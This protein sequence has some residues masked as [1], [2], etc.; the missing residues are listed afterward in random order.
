MAF[1]ISDLTQGT[2]CQ[3]R[4]RSFCLLSP[5]LSFGSWSC[6]NVT[7]DR[8][9]SPLTVTKGKAGPFWEGSQI[10]RDHFVSRRGPRNK[11]L[12][13][14]GRKHTSSRLMGVRLHNPCTRMNLWNVHVHSIN[15]LTR[16]M[17]V[18]IRSI[19]LSALG[20]YLGVS[21]Q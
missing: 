11:W 20:I 4:I 12:G 18:L 1:A 5:G 10:G 16:A 21:G 2:G 8:F 7:L 19:G 13:I 15:L 14:M 3:D 6:Q 9:R 17:R